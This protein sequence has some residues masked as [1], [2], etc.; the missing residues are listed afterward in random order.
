MRRAYTGLADL[1]RALRALN[2]EPRD[3]PAIAG[4]LG[5]EGDFVF[6]Q[7]V[8][9][10]PIVPPAEFRPAALGVAEEEEAS[11]EVDLDTEAE[12]AAHAETEPERP[13]GIRSKPRR[14]IPEPRVEPPSENDRLRPVALTQLRGPAST[15]MPPFI[16]QAEEFDFPDTVRELPPPSPLV[17][18][19]QM[20]ALASDLIFVARPGEP[21]IARLVETMASGRPL[22]NIPRKSRPGIASHVHVLIDDSGAMR[23][24]QAD[25]DRALRALRQV[26]GGALRSE[27]FGQGPPG[28]EVAATI[29]DGV[30]LVISTFGIG[31][32]D[33]GG[34]QAEAGWLRFAEACRSRGL[35]LVALAPCQ[36][37]RWPSALLRHFRLVPWHPPGAKAR[38]AT[39][40]EL[41]RLATAL[42]LAAAID[43]ALL[44][45]ARRR[46]LPE[47]DASAEI[48]FARSPWIGA[49]NPRVLSLRA[50]WVRQLRAELADNAELLE[51]TRRLLENQR[52]R[53]TDWTRVLFEEELVF[54]ALQTAPGDPAK[55]NGIL[56]RVIRS[57]LGRMKNPATARWALCFLD[58]LP[59]AAQG[60]EAAKLLRTVA[61][62]LLGTTPTDVAE[63]VT[64]QNAAWIFQDKTAVVGVSWTGRNIHIHNFPQDG[65]LELEVP[66]THPKIVM[67]ENPLWNQRPKILRILGRKQGQPRHIPDGWTPAPRLPRLLKLTD[68]AVYRLDDTTEIWKKL[69]HSHATQETIPGTVRSRGNGFCLVDVGLLAKLTEPNI[70]FG[71]GDPDGLEGR[72][73]SVRVLRMD[74]KINDVRLEYGPVVTPPPQVWSQLEAAY[75]SL[76]QVRGTVQA[77]GQTGCRVVVMGVNSFLPLD[78]L[79][80]DDKPVSTLLG[81]EIMC[82]ISYLTASRHLVYL[83]RRII[84]DEA[85]RRACDALDSGTRIVGRIVE[86][87]KGGFNVELDGQVPAFLPRSGYD[88]SPPKEPQRLVGETHEF[89]VVK[90]KEHTNS[91]SLVVDRR[92]LIEAE[93]NAKRQAF[94]NS[95]NVGDVVT[96]HVTNLTDFGAFIDLTGIDGLLHITDMS[97]GR[98]T[99]PSEMLKTGDEVTVK[100]LDINKEKERVSLGLKQLQSNPWDKIEERFPIGKRVKGKITNLVPYGA[101]V[102]LEEGVEGLIHVSQLDE[103]TVSKVKDVLKVGQDVEARVIKV[104][105]AE[106]RISLSVKAAN[107]SEEDLKRESEAL[108]DVYRRKI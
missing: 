33:S 31:G 38:S 97:W 106:H 48:D 93:R 53:T 4:L 6:Q 51:A 60:T 42:S 47:T 81:R 65:D 92:K 27:R 80:N 85:W 54:I 8:S 19:T 25:V 18:A 17:S 72:E 101:F 23:L 55:L 61:S 91:R 37:A 12:D 76:R 30:L 59:E 43:P 1:A 7:S 10:E 44:R 73:I 96:G 63:S 82:Q 22:K 99:H 35:M 77:V 105:K 79:G 64:T 88:I 24:F 62:M 15:P 98:L 26:A 71:G 75:S 107:Y 3:C 57:L 5:L 95:V 13:R 45:A 49:W 16:A 67:V 34:Q 74:E 39:P 9:P 58:E 29:S 108:D 90:I 28:K 104:D 56:A 68:G 103:D 66:A 21:D 11:E 36:P 52:P 89:L 20:R 50:S 41:R 70:L 86:A 40:E 14:F 2:P 83:T 94:L 78:Q 69:R 46:F 100:V 84:D 102:E 87:V 32:G